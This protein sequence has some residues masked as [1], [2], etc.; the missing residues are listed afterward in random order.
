MHYITLHYIT[1]H[2]IT[3]HYIT[4]H[5]ITL[6]YIPIAQPVA[7]L[8]RGPGTGGTVR[9]RVLEF[10]K[11]VRGYENVGKKWG[12]NR[13]SGVWAWCLKV[14]FAVPKTWKCAVKI[15]VLRAEDVKSQQTSFN[16]WKVNAQKG[17]NCSCHY[18]LPRSFAQTTPWEH[19]RNPFALAQHDQ[20]PPGPRCCENGNAVQVKLPGRRQTCGPSGQAALPFHMFFWSDWH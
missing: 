6:H 20:I 12:S 17:P 1:L 2:Y 16:M 9:G 5:Y 19:N 10:E 13:K 15:L 14:P 4:L 8:K 3:S 11:E 7:G 18:L